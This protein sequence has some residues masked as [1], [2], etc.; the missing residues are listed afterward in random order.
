VFGALDGIQ[1]GLGGLECDLSAAQVGGDG[2]MLEGVEGLAHEFGECRGGVGRGGGLH[3]VDAA[4]VGLAEAFELALGARVF[5]PGD[6]GFEIDV[7]F[8]GEVGERCALEVAGEEEGA[9]GVW[10]EGRR[11]IRR[12]ALGIGRGARCGLMF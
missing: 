12:W 2:E 10:G 9:V 6:E 8:V 7:E 11:G 3:V 4:L 5:G 1:D